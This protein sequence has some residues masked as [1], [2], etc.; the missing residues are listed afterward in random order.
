MNPF[1]DRIIHSFKND[2]QALQL[3]G[4]KYESGGIAKGGTH[5]V[6]AVVTAQ[7]PKLTIIPDLSL[8]AALKAPI[9]RPGSA[10]SR[11]EAAQ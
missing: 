5:M 3:V 11:Y 7:M 2:V 8:S 1:D 9:S 10:S 6:T 4:P